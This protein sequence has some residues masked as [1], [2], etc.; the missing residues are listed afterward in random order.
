MFFNQTLLPSRRA[1]G[2]SPSGPGERRR[3]PPNPRPRTSSPPSRPAWTTTS[4]SRSTPTRWRT[5]STR[6]FCRR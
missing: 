2:S 5:R 3:S 1:E 4:S 6:C